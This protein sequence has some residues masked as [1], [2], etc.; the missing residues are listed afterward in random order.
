MDA[1]RQVP[2]TG[3]E[4]P[5]CDHERGNISGPMRPKSEVGGAGSSC[6]GLL[7]EGISSKCARSVTDRLN[8]KPRQVRPSAG[9]MSSSWAS[10]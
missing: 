6:V 3:T 5:K 10:E 2:V 8:T 9:G 1:S 7:A 4:A